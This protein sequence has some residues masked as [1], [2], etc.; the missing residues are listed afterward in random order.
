MFSS[1]M[2]LI[3]EVTA[4]R[5][6]LGGV[7]ASKSTPSMRYRTRRRVLER[8]DVDVGGVGL[9]R[10]LDQEVDEADDRRVERHV[11][12]RGEVLASRLVPAL[13]VPH[14]LDDLL[15]RGRAGAEVP[16]D[17]LEDRRLGGDRQPHVEPEACRAVRPRSSGRSGPRRRPPGPRPRR[18]AGR[19]GTGA[20]TG[21]TAAGGRA[22][23]RGTR[24]AR[25]RGS[26]GDGPG[27]GRPP[28]RSRGRAA[29]ACRADAHRSTGG[30]PRPAPA[31]P[32]RGGRSRSA[33]V[34]RTGNGGNPWGR[35][36]I[37]LG[38]SIRYRRGRG[39]GKQCVP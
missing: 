24:P 4:A 12:E 13:V 15:D 30:A 25:R 32:P 3:R 7:S 6:R 26:R 22:G 31:L 37:R 36:R 10:V 16:L 33:I 35:S 27:L 23:S 29:R 18:P 39:A 14:R 20:C 19:S 11:P 9:D 21:A 34:R 28:P 8:L 17:R 2:I 38:N 1:A 5:R